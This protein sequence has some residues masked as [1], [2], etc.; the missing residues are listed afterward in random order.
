MSDAA[1][2]VYRSIEEAWAHHVGEIMP[3]HE[4]IME[5]P[6]SAIKAF[7]FGGATANALEGVTACPLPS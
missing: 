3:T 2:D 7:F 6:M 4:E 5:N 1:A